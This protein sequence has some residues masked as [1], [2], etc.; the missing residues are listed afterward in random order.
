MRHDVKC[1][2]NLENFSYLHL[3]LNPRRLENFLEK[4]LQCLY[5]CKML[6]EKFSQIVFM[7][8]LHLNALF[9]AENKNLKAARINQIFLSNKQ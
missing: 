1:S 5:K 8:R 3:R 2:S 7:Q 6:L 9:R 4:F